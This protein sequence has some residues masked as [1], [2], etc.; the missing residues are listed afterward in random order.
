MGGIGLLSSVRTNTDAGHRL[1][2][3]HP[4]PASSRKF[5]ECPR[6][7]NDTRVTLMPTHL[8]NGLAIEAAT[9]IA[10]PRPEKK[11]ATEHPEK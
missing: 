8:T 7:A 9:S 11:A 4:V 2:H 6:A 3:Q 1:S 10:S 5:A